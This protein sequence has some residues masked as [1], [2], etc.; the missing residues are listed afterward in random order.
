MLRSGT[1]TASARVWLLDLDAGGRLDGR[2]RPVTP[3]EL[4]A[5][6]PALSR[7][8]RRLAIIV[9]RPGGRPIR[10]LREIALENGRERILRYLR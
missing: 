9:Y 7:D 8:G 4:D 6:Q 5:T 10:E 2:A 3:P 1:A